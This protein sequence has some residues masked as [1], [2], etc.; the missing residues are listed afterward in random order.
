MK[1]AGAVYRKLKEAK[2]RHLIALYRKYL[3]RTPINCK[4]NYAYI[5]H[6]EDGKEY[7][8]RLCLCHQEKMTIEDGTRLSGVIPHLVDV[9]Q[10]TEDCQN[11]NA[12]VSKHDRNSIKILFEKELSTKNIRESKYPD[13]CALEW[14]LER[15]SVGI[16]ARNGLQNLIDEI[17]KILRP[18]N[19]SGL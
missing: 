5:L 9:C 1:T 12:F 19:R 4:Y 14:V 15:S 11:C 17:K 2:F 7:Q 13:I 6:A 18:R 3:K 8:V 10:A 16:P